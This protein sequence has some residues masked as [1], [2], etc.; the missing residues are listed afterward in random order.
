MAYLVATADGNLG[1][2]ATWGTVDATSLLDS[3]AGNSLLTATPTG[4]AAGVTPGAIT[5]DAI[6]VKIASRAASPVG[7]MTIVLRNVTDA[8]DV[9]GTSVT[10]NVSDI[11]DEVGTPGNTFSGCSIGWFLFKLAAPVLL[12]AGKAYNVRASTSNTNQINLFRDATANNWSRMLRTTTTAAPGAG[13]SMFVLGEWTAAATKTNRVVTNDILIGTDFGGGSLVLASLGIGKGG[14]FQFGS[15][16]ATNY[17]FRI[18]GVI[19]VWV[20]GIFTIGTVA[21]PIPRDSTAAL[22][23]DS[24]TDGDFG[25]VSYGTF[26][27]QGLSRTTAK[28][29]T[30]CKLNTDEAAGQTVLG[31]DTDTG[32]LNGDEIA[33]A[34]TTQTRDQGETATLSGG[35][36]ATTITITAGLAAAHGGSVATKVQAEVILLTRNVRI[37]GVTAGVTGYVTLMAGAVDVDWCLFRYI[38]GAQGAL[39]G[40]VS[41]NSA[42]LTSFGWDFNVHRDSDAAVAFDV[43]VAATVTLTQ[44]HFW[45]GGTTALIDIDSSATGTNLV[46]TDVC[47][48]NDSTASGTAITQSAAGTLTLTRVFVSGSSASGISV[49]SVDATIIGID[50][51]MH[52]NGTASNAALL[53]SGVQRLVL[54]RPVFWRNASSAMRFINTSDVDVTDG[55]YFGNGSQVSVE[56]VGQAVFRNTT[57]NGDASFATT[58]GISISSA[59]DYYKAKFVG[60]SFSATVAHTTADIGGAPSAAATFLDL[61]FVNTVLAAA[62]EIL[63]AVTAAA[64]ADSAFRYQRK[65]GT[66]NTHETVYPRLGTVAYETTTFRTASPSERLTPSGATATF[67]LRSAIKRCPVASTKVITVSVYVR[68]DGSYTGSAPRLIARANPALGYDSDTVL[69]TLSVGAGTWEQL[70][71]TTTPAAEENGVF[72]FYVDCDGSAGNVFVDDW[73]AIQG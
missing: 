5:I 9:A 57:F 48:V 40:G 37:T 50:L 71:G 64:F 47:L 70:T 39:K 13:D 11:P 73:S 67:K 20:E 54:T 15:T 19:Q 32:W 1:T 7:T 18:S 6:A 4:A 51:N 45:S 59:C 41:F 31:V 12:V 29:I 16:A 27:V 2:A 22:E 43:L 17:V 14:T 25:I 8:G 52:G 53:S 34:T 10:I 21:T 38:A 55:V 30:Y 69:D 42:T 63:A 26:T 60:C 33:I 3:Q 49:S 46:L 56:S 66:T 62:T 58:T 65:D 24:G 36:A 61:T 72:E 28:N 68:K 23:L 35:A 44:T